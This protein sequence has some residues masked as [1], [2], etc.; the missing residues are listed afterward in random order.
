MSEAYLAGL[1]IGAAADEGYVGDGV[2]GA[3]E[4]ALRNERGVLAQ[5]ACHGVNLRGLQALAQREGRQ[6]GGQSLGHHRLAATGTA[7]EDDVMA[8]GGSHLQGA[9][10]VLLA[11]DIAEVIVEGSLVLGKL[12]AGVYLGGLQRG[13]AVEE[14]H[15]LHDI[16]GSIDLEIVDHCSF[17]HIVHRYD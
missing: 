2:V 8:S 5:L 3:A 6:Y 15:D 9:L 4:G 14:V 10:D 13:L 7:N 16:V 1:E 12:A 11:L 17:A